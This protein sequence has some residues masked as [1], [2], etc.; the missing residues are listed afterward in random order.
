M[1]GVV[2]E[3]I[4]TTE[5]IEATNDKDV[6]EGKEGAEKL[7]EQ[8]RENIA[9]RVSNKISTQKAVE[10]TVGQKNA[11]ELANK[12]VESA[13]TVDAHI[14]ER[15]A[16]E[17]ELNEQKQARNEEL[18]DNEMESEHVVLI[19]HNIKYSLDPLIRHFEVHDITPTPEVHLYFM[20]RTMKKENRGQII[21]PN[22][23]NYLKKFMYIHNIK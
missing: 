23:V 22:H 6:K 11:A 8:D 16:K 15:S 10:S 20:N 18:V 21:H 2:N 7:T 14:T 17:L 12:A 19:P 3:T 5:S 1:K 9:S 4:A 13:R